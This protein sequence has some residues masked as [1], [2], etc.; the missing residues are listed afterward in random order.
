MPGAMPRQRN[1]CPRLG[2]ILSEHAH[3]CCLERRWSPVRAAKDGLRIRQEHAR[4]KA[5]Y[6]A[7]SVLF[8]ERGACAVIPFPI[9]DTG[10]G[11][12]CTSLA[13]LNQKRGD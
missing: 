1:T 4:V 10:E 13:L 6:S 7:V 11:F 12:L 2:R 3:P 8:T 9:A 5:V